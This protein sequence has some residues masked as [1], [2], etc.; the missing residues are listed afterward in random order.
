M[1]LSEVLKINEELSSFVYEELPHSL[2]YDI[3]LF[4]EKYLADPVKVFL[5]SKKDIEDKVFKDKLNPLKD[6]IELF[7]KE[8]NNL[9]EKEISISEEE[10]GSLIIDKNLLQEMKSKNFYIMIY[11]KFIK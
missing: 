9:L 6:E 1:K 3:L 11:K 2:K 8:L 4:I 7:E 10:I 5:S